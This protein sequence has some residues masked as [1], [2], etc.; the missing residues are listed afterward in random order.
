M[1][2]NYQVLINFSTN[3]VGD[4][5]SGPAWTCSSPSWVTRS[6]SWSSTPRRTPSHS[7][8]SSRVWTLAIRFGAAL[9]EVRKEVELNPFS[10]LQF[11]MYKLFRDATKYIDGRHKK[12]LGAINRDLRK[13]IL[14]D[15]DA[16]STTGHRENALVI[17]KWEGD[18]TD[19]TLIGL[20]QL[21]MGG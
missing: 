1:L 8:P 9:Q 3:T 17:K 15:Y 20:T 10:P 13:V 11:L 4:F 21:L 2:S 18:N 5:K 6:S 19:T 16:E 14:V 7:S 12:D